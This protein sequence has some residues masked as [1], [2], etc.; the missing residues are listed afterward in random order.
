MAISLFAAIAFGFAGSG[1]APHV[2]VL[3]F[4]L[5]VAT[6]LT[7]A[8]VFDCYDLRVAARVRDSL[9]LRRGLSSRPRSFTS[10]SNW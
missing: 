9:P 7:S 2:P 4:G 1:F 10:P 8:A 6:W 3:S 5:L